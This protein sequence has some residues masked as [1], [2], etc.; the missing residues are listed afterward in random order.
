MIFAVTKSCCFLLSLPKKN[1]LKGSKHEKVM[2]R[3]HLSNKFEILSK[4]LN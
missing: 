1:L 3:F 2:S 4:V